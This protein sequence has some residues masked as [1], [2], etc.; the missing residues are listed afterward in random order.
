LTGIILFSVINSIWCLVIGNPSRIYL[1]PSKE[2]RKN[3]SN[4]SQDKIQDDDQTSVY[5]CIKCF[6]STHPLTWHC[7]SFKTTSNACTA[8]SSGTVHP[9]LKWWW[10]CL[11][12][13]VFGWVVNRRRI[14]SPID[15][16]T[17]PYSAANLFATRENQV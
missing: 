8:K 17:T 4:T 15:K 1:C 9:V 3:S 2:N 7:G 11:T 12:R 13:S 14:T 6:Y 5:C 16:R 10:I